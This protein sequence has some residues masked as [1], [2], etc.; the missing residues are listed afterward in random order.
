MMTKIMGN[1]ILT[2]YGHPIAY[3]SDILSDTVW[4]YPTYDK[5]IYS[6]I[7]SCRQWKHYIMEKETIVYTTTTWLSIAPLTI[8]HF[9]WGWDSNPWAPLMLHYLLQPH[10]KNLPMFSM[11]L[12]KPP[13]SLRGFNTS[14]NRSVITL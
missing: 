11:R 10:R 2:Q 3:H 6:N 1:T 4:K 8:A 7:Q 13:N 14:T 5:E 12:T 9:R